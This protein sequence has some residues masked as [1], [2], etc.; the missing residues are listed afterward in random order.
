MFMKSSL[1]MLL[2]QKKSMVKIYQLIAIVI[3]AAIFSSCQKEIL[4]NPVN[5]LPSDAVQS[6]VITDTTLKVDA[7]PARRLVYP[8]SQAIKLFGRGSSRLGP[9]TYQWTQISS[10]S[11]AT[12]VS[13]HEDT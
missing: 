5:S 9:V 3:A 6:S 1:R 13:P 10:N 2:I 8:L 7:G 4:S 12:I 11:A